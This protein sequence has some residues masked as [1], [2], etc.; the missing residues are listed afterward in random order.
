MYEKNQIDEIIDKYHLKNNYYRD[1]IKK[2]QWGVAGH[3]GRAK[4]STNSP[5]KLWSL[6]FSGRLQ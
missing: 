5:G 4:L 3:P 6:G 2:K 1:N